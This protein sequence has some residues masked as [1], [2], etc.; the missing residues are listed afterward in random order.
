MSHDQDGH[1]AHIIKVK[2]FFSG[3]KRPMTLKLGLQHWLL[4]YDEVCSNDDTGLTLTC[5]TARSNLIPSLLYG[6]M[7]KL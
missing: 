5:F 4:E 1:H 3:T 2:I 7:L 6:K